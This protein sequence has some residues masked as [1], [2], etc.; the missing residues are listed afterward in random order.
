MQIRPG[1]EL[2]NLTDVGCHRTENEDYYCYI[3]P[4]SDLDFLRKGRL[5]VVAD[6][7]GG[8]E[9]GK[10]ASTIAVETVR[11]GYLSHPDDD[12]CWR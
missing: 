10:V 3:E 11:D 8:H 7:M 9:G 1:M 5:A 4:E 2:A 12:P 6:G